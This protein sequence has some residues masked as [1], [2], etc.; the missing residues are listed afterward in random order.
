MRSMSLRPILAAA[1]LASCTRSP[2]AT[3]T[4]HTPGIPSATTA[5]P[6]WTTRSDVS[7]DEATA[8]I[9][10]TGKYETATFAL[11]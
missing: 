10:K 3:M 1:I 5:S 11:G 8:E 4:Q 2:S 9:L 7:L 6:H